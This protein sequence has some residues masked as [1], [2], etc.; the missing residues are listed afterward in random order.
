MQACCNAF[1]Y[2]W[3]LQSNT[4]FWLLKYLNFLI[5]FSA[6]RTWLTKKLRW[7]FGFLY[8]ALHMHMSNFPPKPQDFLLL[9]FALQYFWCKGLL[10]LNFA[11]A[12]FPLTFGKNILPLNVYHS[13]FNTQI[14]L[15]WIWGYWYNGLDVFNTSL[16]LF[17]VMLKDKGQ[18]F[19]LVT[20]YTQC[21]PFVWSDPKNQITQSNKVVN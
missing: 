10:P 5:F 8:V 13:N 2:S 19:N 4:S 18:Y 17:S 9:I 11:T 3:R 14:L 6:P 20:C 15:L 12:I 16:S 7:V 21:C 1:E